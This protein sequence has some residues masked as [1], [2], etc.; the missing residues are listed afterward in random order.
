MENLKKA[1]LNMYLISIIILVLTFFIY[2]LFFT[3][4]QGDFVSESEDLHCRSLLSAKSTAIVKTGEFLFNDI[5]TKCKKDNIQEKVK[6]QEEVFEVV[7][8]SMVRCWNRYGAGKYDFLSS[9]NKGGNWCFTCARLEF[10]DKSNNIGAYSF[11]D[12]I[13]WM[14]QTSL[15]LSNG[16]KVKYYNYIN[17]K[18]VK[19]NQNDAY[20]LKKDIDDLLESSQG[21]SVSRDIGIMLTQQYKY[22]NDLRLKNIDTNNKM[23]VVYRYDKGQ[24]DISDSMKN[25]MY[26]AG[27]G[28]GASIVGSLVAENIFNWGITGAVCATIGWTGVGTPVCGALITYS[29]YKTGTTT[30]K[31]GVQTVKETSK[32][33]K[34]TSQFNKILKFSKTQKQLNTIRKY[35]GSIDGIDNI[36]SNL[37][38]SEKTKNLVNDFI[39]I[40]S[41]MRHLNVKNIADIDFSILSKKDDLARL[42]NLYTHS[43]DVLFDTSRGLATIKD[44]NKMEKL[45]IDKLQNLQTT[46]KTL[47]TDLKNLEKFT[48]MQK[49]NEIKKTKEMIL[50]NKKTL[51]YGTV[52]VAGTVSGAYI[53]ESMN[54]NSNQYVDLMTAEQYYRLCGTEPNNIN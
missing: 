3:Q 27:I 15:K 5:V 10:D 53:G 19:I 37:Q 36:V 2:I 42:N 20:E 34:I 33:K 50:E 48:G 14:N 32:I 29:G 23:Y 30:A 28:L 4:I 8:D 41:E 17:I 1:N 45:E 35:D 16:T 12:Y 24:N 31:A 6:T 26:G 44:L 25:I 39:H 18:Y 7:G 54:F 40:Q 47:E 51:I 38:K 52:A 43:S 22:M 49:A 11:N 9:Y 21:D 13:N 46:I